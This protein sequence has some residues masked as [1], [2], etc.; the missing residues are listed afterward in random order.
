M[1]SKARDTFRS[2]I[3]PERVEYAYRMA[4]EAQQRRNDG[5]AQIGMRAARARDP[6]FMVALERMAEITGKM[7]D[8]Q[9]GRTK[10]DIAATFGETRGTTEHQLF[11]EA[12]KTADSGNAAEPLMWIYGAAAWMCGYNP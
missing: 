4:I 3:S 11:R 8:E 2:E 1:D 6:R 9:I 5:F 10:R 7:E 12:Y